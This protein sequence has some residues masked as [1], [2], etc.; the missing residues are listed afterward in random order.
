MLPKILG[1]GKKHD[2]KTHDATEKN[3][4]LRVQI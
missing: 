3:C 4:S 1:M 2:Y